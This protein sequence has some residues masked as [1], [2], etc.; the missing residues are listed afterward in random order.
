MHYTKKRSK[1]RTV[2]ANQKQYG[3]TDVSLI[4]TLIILSLMI[5]LSLILLAVRVI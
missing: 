1:M 4:A 3:S 2:H 5:V